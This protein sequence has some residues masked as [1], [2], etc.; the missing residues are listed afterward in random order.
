MSINTLT[1]YL[2]LSIEKP[3]ESLEFIEIA[4]RI[5]FKLIEKTTAN[6]QPSNPISSQITSPHEKVTSLE[7]IGESAREKYDQ[8]KEG[9]GSNLSNHPGNVL[10]EQMIAVPNNKT[11]Q[12]LSIIEQN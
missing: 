7:V 11:P 8:S 9:Y 1:G 6:A 5:A 2:L 4:E 10:S 3:V 12:E